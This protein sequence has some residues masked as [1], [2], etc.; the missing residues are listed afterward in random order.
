VSKY[1]IT[2]RPLVVNPLWRWSV[3][4]VSEINDYANVLC[5]TD[6]LCSGKA[7][8]KQTAQRA[9]ETAARKIENDR[10]EIY[11]FEV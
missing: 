7:P 6:V 11:I 10:P 2:L 4:S 1:K 3:S 8:S 9:A 5:I